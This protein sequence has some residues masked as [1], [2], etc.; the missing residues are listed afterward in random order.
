MTQ[1][2]DAISLSELS[3]VRYVLIP[4][5]YVQGPEVDELLRLRTKLDDLLTRLRTPPPPEEEGHAAAP[6]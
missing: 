4:R 5:A 3:F 6:A 2:E 1:P